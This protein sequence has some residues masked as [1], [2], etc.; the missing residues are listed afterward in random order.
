MHKLHFCKFWMPCIIFKSFVEKITGNYAPK[1]VNKFPDSVF[2]FHYWLVTMHLH[3][4]GWAYDY[5]FDMHAI[6]F[7]IM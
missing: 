2:L 3:V 4:K 6:K 5:I 1:F 7:Y